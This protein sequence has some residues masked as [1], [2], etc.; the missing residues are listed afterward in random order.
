MEAQV[1]I[2]LK[3]AHLKRY[4]DIVRLLFKYGRGDLASRAA[5]STRT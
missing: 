5:P 1:A 2:S 3:P 4:K